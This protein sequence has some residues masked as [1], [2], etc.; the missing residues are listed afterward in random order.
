VLWNVRP[1]SIIVLHDY[2]GRGVRTADALATI[3]PG[4][5]RRGFRV[6]TLSELMEGR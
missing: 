5:K 1:G 2:G 4:L 6:V 3:L